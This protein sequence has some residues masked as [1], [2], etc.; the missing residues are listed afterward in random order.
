M[1]K[2]LAV[3][4][5]QE[6]TEEILDLF[7]QTLP[8]EQQAYITNP[9]FREQALEQLVS[10][11]LFAKKGEDDKLEETEEFQT[12]IANAKRDILAQM[13]MRDVL[14]TAEVSE[15]ENVL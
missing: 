3:V 1:S 11:F 9:Q 2:V 6:I 13:A 15:E 5:G 12:V 8:R 10:L 14:K 7:L 4:A